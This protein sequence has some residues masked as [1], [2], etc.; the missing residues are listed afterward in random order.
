MEVYAASNQA[1][2][3]RNLFTSPPPK[4]SEK[5]DEFWFTVCPE[6]L[7][8]PLLPCESWNDESQ[9]GIE[10]Q[11]SSPVS[12]SRTKLPWLTQF[13]GAMSEIYTAP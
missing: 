13:K 1:A 10:M 9:G 11:R 3:V 7:T 4:K 2:W 5:V 8:M 12:M 6:A